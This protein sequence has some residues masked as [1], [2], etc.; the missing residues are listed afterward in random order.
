M[1]HSIDSI[2]FFGGPNTFFLLFIEEANFEEK[3]KALELI[4]AKVSEF[5]HTRTMANE[6]PDRRSDGWTLTSSRRRRF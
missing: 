3:L 1:T 5:T 4:I 6:E 2:G